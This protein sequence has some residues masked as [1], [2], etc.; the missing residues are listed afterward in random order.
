MIRFVERRIVEVEPR[1][2][3]AELVERLV[4]IEG[5]LPVDQSDRGRQVREP[6][7]QQA[8]ED[9]AGDLPRLAPRHERDQAGLEPGLEPGRDVDPERQRL[10][11]GQ[12][13]P[14]GHEDVAPLA[15][16]PQGR[17]SVGR[18]AARSRRPRSSRA[19]ARSMSRISATFVA[20]TIRLAS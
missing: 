4:V 14:L 19:P 10:R 3:E 12:H 20:P 9:A 11:R 7:R 5:R 15:E 18:G 2:L 16:P 1:G 6:G 13:A 8:G 17:V